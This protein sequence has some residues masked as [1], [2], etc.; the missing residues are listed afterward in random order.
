MS[1]APVRTLL[2]AAALLVIGF[3]ISSQI[4]P[5]AAE[6]PAPK[7]KPLNDAFFYPDFKTRRITRFK[8]GEDRRQF[9]ALT[10]LGGFEILSSDRNIGGLSGV[11]SLEGGKQLLMLTD[12][13]RWVFAE[14]DQTPNG[15]P[16][17][18]E[19]V[20]YAQ[21]RNAKGET[22]DQSW[23]HNTEAL[24]V[25]NNAIYVAAERANAIYEFPWPLKT[26]RDRMRRQLKVSD[27]IK[28]LPKNTGL[29]GLAA[30]PEG[31][32]M[33]DTLLAVAER[34]PKDSTL[35]PAYLFKG[36]AEARFDIQRSDNYDATDAAFLPGGD[37]LLLERRFNL[38]DLLGMRIRRFA[39][40]SLLPGAEL[41]GEVLL[42]AD[43][44]Y[45]IDN[46]EGLAVHQ[47]NDGK[48]I[49]TVVSDNNR[50]ILQR[51]LLLR[52]ELHN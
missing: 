32:L 2:S 17:G 30:G 18:L 50:S 45:Q 25:L 12:N 13:G 51:T 39:A 29:E 10:Y 34:S 16:I 36:G 44:T 43:F 7:A 40:A 19:S 49:L 47:T 33:Q 3:C 11:L 1:K 21:L 52:F 8:I 15:T 26:G 31:S 38:R 6:S 4:T 22:L 42:D 23:G 37:L 41:V 46:M 5:A 20:R 27:G 35:L 24:A 9:G 14:L 28:S 48:T